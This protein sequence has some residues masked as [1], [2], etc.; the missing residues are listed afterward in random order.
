MY[1]AILNKRKLSSQD[2]SFKLKVFEFAEEHNN[3]AAAHEFGID[4]CENGV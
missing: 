4:E 1:N 2:A 3:S